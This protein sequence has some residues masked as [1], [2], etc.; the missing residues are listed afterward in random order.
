MSTPIAPHSIHFPGYGYFWVANSISSAVLGAVT[1]K[2]RDKANER[3]E[4]F[5][6]ELR[7]AQ[8]LTDEKRLQEEMAFKRHLLD[9]SRQYHRE[10]TA[11]QFINKL[12]LDELKYY[13]QNSWPLDP[14]LPGFLIDE[15]K[16]NREELHPKLNVILLQTQLLPL[17]KLG[18]ANEQDAELYRGLEYAIMRKD[19][20]AIKDLMYHK[21][22]G[23]KDPT[24]GVAIR[25]GGNAIIMNIHF[26]MNQLPTL[27][28]SPQY[29]DGEMFF[30][31]AVWESLS[32]RPLIR[33][34]FSFEYDIIEAN[35]N[36]EYRDS[37]M[38]KFR[39][40]VS[41]IMGCV[42][43]SYIMLTQGGS[44]TLPI[45]LNDREHTEIK[46]LVSKDERMKSFIRQEN[47]AIISALDYSKNPKLLNVYSETEIK[48][49]IEQ[50]RSNNL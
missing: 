28:I 6:K 37:Q 21:D 2:A 25:T 47:I 24:R 13:I 14:L 10:E 32:T 16:N 42:R 17:R 27:I 1:R 39:A 22:A 5:Q 48:S 45:W 41:I 9:L 26:L 43:D 12:K 40:A 8:E 30:N 46:Q 44:P 38:R 23:F 31:G 29:R 49:I 33:P 7:H 3:N 11:I 36:H 50:V 34:L 35:T 15:I 19:V 4:L 20:P 18:G